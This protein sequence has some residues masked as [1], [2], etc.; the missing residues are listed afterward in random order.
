MNSRR[1]KIRKIGI[2]ESESDDSDYNDESEARYNVQ[3]LMMGDSR[4]R[5]GT[6][7]N[8]GQM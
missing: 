7:F 5:N 3:I 2:S 4:E 6:M 8:D 1:H